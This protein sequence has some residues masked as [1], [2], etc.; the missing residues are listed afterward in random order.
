MRY[1]SQHGIHPLLIYISKSVKPR[2]LTVLANFKTPFNLT[3]TNA[4][5]TKTP[6]V[7]TYGICYR[8]LPSSFLSHS[9]YLSI[10]LT[11]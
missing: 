1:R 3:L 7:N 11:T 5:E 9:N 4:Y 8:M 2:I 6:F 10:L